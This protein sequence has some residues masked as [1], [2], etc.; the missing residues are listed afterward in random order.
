MCCTEAE[1]AT[2]AHTNTSSLH[3]SSLLLVP[4]VNLQLLNGRYKLMVTFQMSKAHTNNYISKWAILQSTLV[5]VGF[6]CAT[7]HLEHRTW[8]SPAEVGL[9][10]SKVT[11]FF[12]FSYRALCPEVV[13]HDK[14]HSLDTGLCEASCLRRGWCK[15]F[16]KHY[17]GGTP[18]I[19]AC[20]VIN[21][22]WPSN[23]TV[24]GLLHGATNDEDIFRRKC[25]GAEM[26]KPQNVRCTALRLQ[27]HKH[28]THWLNICHDIVWQWSKKM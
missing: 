23:I 5:R 21:R 2:L 18:R 14:G 24:A 25:A 12:R 26:L 20:Y 6:S 22:L 4:T 19:S 7:S 27:Q 3:D 8:S 10:D 11:T 15:A 17:R 13:L 1:E 28:G 16:W 9:C